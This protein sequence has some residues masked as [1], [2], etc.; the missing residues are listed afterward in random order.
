ME[1]NDG[2]LDTSLVD[3]FVDAKVYERA[4]VLRSSGG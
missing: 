1:V 4:G 2:L 3:L